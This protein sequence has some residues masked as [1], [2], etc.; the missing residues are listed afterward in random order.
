MRAGKVSESD[1]RPLPPGLGSTAGKG[2]GE[3]CLPLV[4]REKPSLSCG[5]AV[6]DRFGVDAFSRDGD[7]ERELTTPA[8]GTWATLAQHLGTP[9][10]AP[11]SLQTWP[12]ASDT[13]EGS[14]EGI[15]FE[16]RTPCT[17][18]VLVNPW[19]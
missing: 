9:S 19:P 12:Q 10:R 3:H 1:A 4:F 6:S 18:E 13:S 7:S 2:W 5:E 14:Y 8:L 11:M 16:I 15:S 17:K